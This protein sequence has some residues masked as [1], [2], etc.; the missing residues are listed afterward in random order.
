MLDTEDPEVVRQE[1]REAWGLDDAQ[2]DAVA[3]VTL[4]MGYSNLSEKAIRKILPHLERGLAFSDAVVE[5]G[6]PHHSDFRSAESHDE[7]P[8]YG[9]VLERDA[10]GADHTKDPQKDGEPERYGRF[11][12]PTVHIGLNQ[13]RR[14]VNRLIEVYGKPE[15]IVVELARDL[16][17]NLE[18]KQRYRRQQEEG[19][20]RNE[21]LDEMLES[22][23]QTATPHMRRKF[24]LWEEQGPI[25]ARRCPF[26]GDPI[27]FNMVVSNQTEI[28]HILPFSR[29]LDDSPANKVLCTIQ[30]NRD[31][32]DRSPFEAFGHNPPEYKYDEIL[33]RARALPGNKRW[34]FDPDAMEQFERTRDFLDRQ[35]NETRYLSRT[36]RSYLACLY[37]EKAE[38]RQ[39]V[40]AIPGFMTALLRRAWGLEGM[41]RVSETGEI[42]RKQRDDHRH[43]AIDALVVANTAQGLLQR[44]AHAASSRF[45]ERADRLTAV[46]GDVRP[47]D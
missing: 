18:Q 4:P 39:R 8:Y 36:A 29:T 47:W 6:Y 41:L 21:R 17:A 30:A 46:A 5:A 3:H 43:H 19:K 2:A 40:F 12:N 14:V 15:E 42:V 32:G 9:V 37:D 31:K 10:V 28:E 38:G 7:L 26:S 11:P 23:G 44:F 13:L 34:R 25:H 27:S 22:E 24:R 20:E 33:T 45:E 35:L 16:K 1:A